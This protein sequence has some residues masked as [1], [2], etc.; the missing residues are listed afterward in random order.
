MESAGTSFMLY[1]CAKEM[2]CTSTKGKSNP[3]KE[4]RKTIEK[5]KKKIFGVI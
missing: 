3:K 5:N 2:A 4:G 1:F